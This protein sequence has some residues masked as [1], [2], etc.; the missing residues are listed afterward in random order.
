MRWMVGWLGILGI[1]GVVV[2]G[3]GSSCQQVEVLDRRKLLQDTVDIVILPMV[4]AFVQKTRALKTAGE[5]LCKQ[6][7]STTIEAIRAAWRETKLAWKRTEIVRFGPAMDL[8]TRSFVD[9]W[10]LQIDGV[11]KV[12]TS[13]DILDVKYIEDTLGSSRRGLAAI[14]YLIFDREKPT[15]ERLQGDA[16]QGGRQCA[17]LSASLT[18]LDTRSAAY[19]QAW[20]KDGG[21]FGREMVE[22]GRDSK[23]FVTLQAPIDQLINESVYWVENLEQTK[24]AA[25]LGKKSGTNTPQPTQVES[26]WGKL[27]KES[28]LANLE[29]LAALYG[30]DYNGKSGVSLYDL[31]TSRGYAPVVA[32]VKAQFQLAQ[33]A[34]SSIK[35]PLQDALASENAQVET[36]YQAVMELR[37]ILATEVSGALGT[38]LNFTDNDGD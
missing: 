4:E 24:L 18:S 32:K 15:L 6:P 11:E 35:A 8:R 25:P 10:P 22:A 30:C 31:L 33:Q 7:D 27:S 16:A 20:R 5:A 14:E 36:A 23:V 38:V 2:L 19:G 29:A 28:I 12:L 37:K 1:L 17:F 34:L 26:L 9:W 21:N 13:Q 3:V